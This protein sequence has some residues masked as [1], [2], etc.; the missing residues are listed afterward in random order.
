MI[1]F[2]VSFNTIIGEADTVLLNNVENNQNESKSIGTS[3]S[4]IKAKIT[5]ANTQGIPFV[6]NPHCFSIYKTL[7]KLNLYTY[8]YSKR[9]CI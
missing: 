9:L 1:I 7:Y 8:R 5:K 4:R 3:E 6:T 2:P